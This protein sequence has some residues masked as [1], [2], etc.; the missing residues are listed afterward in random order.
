VLGD[1]KMEEKSYVVLRLIITKSGND[2]IR[3]KEILNLEYENIENTKKASS[4]LAAILNDNTKEFICFG[5]DDKGKQKCFVR[6]E[7][8]DVESV[9][10]EDPEIEKAKDVI[11]EIRSKV[12]KIL[13]NQESQPI[14]PQI[15]VIPLYS[16]PC[17]DYWRKPWWPYR[18]PFVVTY[19][20]T[21]GPDSTG[22]WH[23]TSSTKLNIGETATN[24]VN[25]D[26]L[27]YTHTDFKK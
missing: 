20:I 15:Q 23:W 5:P 2:N 22:D 17:D 1:N 27:T 24:S 13:K 9:I 4:E 19:A 11:E 14:I 7:L 26:N 12:G 25:G 18:E 16:A 10:I 3:I 21:T 6:I 8:D